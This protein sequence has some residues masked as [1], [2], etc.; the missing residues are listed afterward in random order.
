MKRLKTTRSLI[1]T[2]VPSI[3]ELVFVRFERQKKLSKSQ[4]K[5][6]PSYRVLMGLPV[7]RKTVK[8]LAFRRKNC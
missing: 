5:N 4:L 3:D 1:I 6:L 7:S 8:K 2:S